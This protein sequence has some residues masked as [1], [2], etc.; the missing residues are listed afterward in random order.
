MPR[1]SFDKV[2]IAN[3]GEIA[4]RIQKACKA[5]G[6]DCV[7]ICSDVDK[8]SYFARHAAELY[9][10]GG[11]SAAES[12]L[13]IEKIVGAAKATDCQAVHPGYGFLSENA[14]FARAVTNAGL[15]FIGPSAESIE[16]L[17]NK[18]LARERV[19]KFGV[20]CTPGCKGGL[21]DKEIE[22]R[23]E[24]IGLPVILKAVAGGGG[25]G[26]RVARTKSELKE[27]LPRARAEAKKFFSNDDV[28]L[29]K[30]IEEPRHIEVQVFGDT[31]GNIIHFGTRD[32]SSQRRHQKLVE[33]APA[34]FLAKA[35]TNKIQNAAVK[36][37]RSVDY[38]GAGT[39]E[40]LLSGKDFYFL[41]MNTRIQVEHP[42]SEEVTGYDLVG[43]QLEVAKG[44]KVPAQSKVEIKGHSI[45]YRIYAEDARNGFAPQT[46]KISFQ[47][48]PSDTTVRI[49]FG[50]DTGDKI[51]PYYDAL[52]S[53][54]IVTG[55]T[56]DE[57]ID[58]SFALLSDY[59]IE[60]FETT[61]PFHRWIL[62]NPLFR[63][64]CVDIG[65][66]DREFSAECLD[67]LE[68]SEIRDPLHRSGVGNTE[69]LDIFQYRSS[70]FDFDYRIEVL[71]RNDGIFVA[72]PADSKGRRAQ[73]RHCRASN[74]L[75]T[76]ISSLANEVLES[77]P[78]NKVLAGLS[79]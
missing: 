54:L 35:L 16:I 78:P 26:M 64:D 48:F 38:V 37:A 2:L 43:L 11:A 30:Y 29:E 41:E 8:G 24:E 14:D 7:I 12:Y 5:K 45:E 23:A 46:G 76:A 44:A 79:D 39:V 20:P 56:R 58:K 67:E 25:R 63:N 72:T 34:P 28:Y 4:L 66:I 60:G 3:R 75:N 53:K 31:H 21:S 61:I 22:A 59:K 73:A 49:D 68:A 10:I 77:V 47:K 9:P 52:I 74:G 33:E 13:D 57:V 27:A 65:Y 70:A 71:H 18:T 1:P 17:G 55:S 15:V 62:K 51:S 42:V 40:F 50:F 32:C 6:I 69:V 19:E 36:A